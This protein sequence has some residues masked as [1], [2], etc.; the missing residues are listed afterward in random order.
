MA[1]TRFKTLLG[2]YPITAALKSGVVASPDLA[3]DFADVKVP[4]TAF[5]RV[6]RDLEFDVAELAIVTYLMAKAQNV[7][8]TL[9]PAV[10]VGR[11][12]H[13]YIV[14]NAARGELKP[15]DLNGRTIGIRSHTVTTVAWLRGILADDYG[16]DLDSIRWV[17]FED[18]HVAGYSD[19][20]GV[21]RA[22]SDKDL[23]SMLV[24]GEIDA[25]IMTGT[26]GNPD[27]KPLIVN[28]DEAAQRWHASNTAIQINH[29][30]VVRSSLVQSNPDLV[31]QVYNMLLE[32]KHASG[33]PKPGEIDM[34][35][36]GVTANRRNLD[37]IIDFT[38]RQGLIPRKPDV[39][40]L[41]D[42]VTVAL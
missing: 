21:V 6:V 30:V 28:P 2:D 31:R 40:E 4:N 13:P 25:A 39:E 32:S 17:T 22:G 8:L 11:F 20:P 14:F 9:L 1:A 23:K 5:K 29:L 41:F 36:F 27:I 18:P 3:L 26:V 33:L 16:V 38:F 10:V 12:Q 24:D 7:P 37:V 34:N 15:A 19:P 42:D 35:P